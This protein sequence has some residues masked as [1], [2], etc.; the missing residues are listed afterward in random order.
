MTIG[1]SWSIF[2]SSASTGS[3]P[4]SAAPSTSRGGAL[5]DGAFNLPPAVEHAVNHDPFVLYLVHEAVR[6]HQQ[7]PKARIGW[8]RVWPAPLAELL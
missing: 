5:P 2:N 4:R 3:S 7:L 8:I 1:T 6:A